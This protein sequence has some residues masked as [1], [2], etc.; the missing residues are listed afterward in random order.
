MNRRETDMLSVE[1]K[2]NGTMVGHIYARNVTECPDLADT[3]LYHWEYYKPE[4]RTARRGK[5]E[6]KRSKDIEVLIATILGEMG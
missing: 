5:V 2:V 6:H 1:L 4:Q 3:N